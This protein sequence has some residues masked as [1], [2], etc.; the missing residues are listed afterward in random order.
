MINAYGTGSG[1]TTAPAATSA[2]PRLQDSG[3]NSGQRQ[4]RVTEATQY[5]VLTAGG[6]VLGVG[7]VFTQ[8]ELDSRLSSTSTAAVSS[9]TTNLN[10]YEGLWHSALLQPV[11]CWIMDGH[12]RW[13]TV[14]GTAVGGILVP[15]RIKD[16]HGK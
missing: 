6:R 12:G 11:C 13:A 10:S 3:N 16:R 7:S 8:A 14:P 5:G 2:A 4:Y 9:L 1:T 15:G